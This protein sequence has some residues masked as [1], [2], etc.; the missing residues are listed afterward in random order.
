MPESVVQIGTVQYNWLPALI[1]YVSTEC[2]LFDTDY[3][4]SM[5]A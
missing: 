5:S 1:Y 4:R 3:G 2:T